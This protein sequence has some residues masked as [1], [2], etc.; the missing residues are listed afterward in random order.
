MIYARYGSPQHKIL[1]ADAA[2]QP[3]IL[4]DGRF[5]LTKKSINR[6]FGQVSK[7]N[8]LNEFMQSFSRYGIGATGL[9]EKLSRPIHFESA[10]HEAV[11]SIIEAYDVNTVLEACEFLIFAK[12]EGFLSVI[13]LKFAK[14][15]QIL[16]QEDK[17]NSLFL[18]I[19]ETTGLTFTKDKA[20]QR[21]VLSFAD[22]NREKAYKWIAAFPDDFWNLVMSHLQTDWK[23]MR[24]D[25]LPAA[26]F[27]RDWVFSRLP[28]SLFDEM[29]SKAPKRSYRLK[30]GPQQNQ[31]PQ[32]SSYLHGLIAL[33]TVSEGNLG[34]LD[35]LLSK[36]YPVVRNIT[37]TTAEPEL[38]LTAFSRQVKN[39]LAA[40][41]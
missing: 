1:I 25:P 27:V 30:R 17:N 22:H 32:I 15:A 20:Q 4:S 9:L 39:L 40:V 11:P 37:I 12:N 8:W 33:Y 19:A 7:A 10:D 5:V 38:E 26:H 16:I 34:I 18:R 21:I 28:S 29:R 35:Q 13:E 24:E 41:K 6:Y 31:H 36:S 2:L 23:S 3:Y 14:A